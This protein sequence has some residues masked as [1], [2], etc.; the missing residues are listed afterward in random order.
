MNDEFERRLRDALAD[1]VPSLPDNPDRFEQV[2]RAARRR[3]A[4]TGLSVAAV[5]LAVIGAV[6]VPVVLSATTESGSRPPFAGGL[7]TPGPSEQTAES[8]GSPGTSAQ[9]DP[10]TVPCPPIA[11][12]A[13]GDPG[14]E[15]TRGTLVHPGATA[16]R[17][18]NVGLAGNPGRRDEK[19][20]LTGERVDRLVELLN[21]LT[22]EET[23]GCRSILGV[24]FDVALRYPDGGQVVVSGDTGE[25]SQVRADDEIRLGADRVWLV[26]HDLM[27]EQRLAERPLPLPPSPS[28]GRAPKCPPD[29]DTLRSSSLALSRGEEPVPF[30]ATAVTL[31][32]FEH[33]SSGR[34]PDVLLDSTSLT[35]LDGVARVREAVNSGTGEALTC[36]MPSGRYLID[37][38]VFS[39]PA[40]GVSSLAVWRAECSRMYGDSVADQ[41]TPAALLDVLDA[42]LGPVPAS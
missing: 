34:P 2:R 29:S 28:A 19:I 18:C 39:D 8:P 25:C 33:H 16:A 31:C 15:E 42:V 17:L 40:G 21:G 13:D 5:V 27:E 7:R 24:T 36:Q 38:L 20:V 9:A 1:A 23:D 12:N 30:D 14:P 11:G 3:R 26:T 37:V 4:L 35:D 32:R 41:A 10:V 6:L 22:W